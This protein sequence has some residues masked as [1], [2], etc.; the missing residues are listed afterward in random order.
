M[1]KF[2]SALCILFGLL[3][4]WGSWKSINEIKYLKENGIKAEARII[5]FNVK[6][7]DGKKMFTPVYKFVDKYGNEQIHV[8]KSSTSCSGLIYGDM[9][10]RPCKQQIGD[11]DE[12]I[13]DPNEPSNAK[14]NSKMNFTYIPIILAFVGIILVVIGIKFITKKRI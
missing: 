4:L 6:D 10:E 11:I 12:I 1:K 7:D 3:L 9:E 14:I 8:S 2:V 5:K 13:Y